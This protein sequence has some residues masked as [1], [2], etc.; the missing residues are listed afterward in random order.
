M[1]DWGEVGWPAVTFLKLASLLWRY[2]SLMSPDKHNCPN[3]LFPIIANKYL[4]QTRTK[5]RDLI[6]RIKHGG[7]AFPGSGVSPSDGG[8]LWALLVLAGWYIR[9]GA[10]EDTVEPVALVQTCVC[11]RIEEVKLSWANKIHTY[12]GALT[13]HGYIVP[14]TD[15]LWDGKGRERDGGWHFLMLV[16]YEVLGQL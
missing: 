9:P 5:K 11:A 7:R 12:L 13:R 14:I 3:D 1:L 16:W 10:A 6:N 15:E 2:G 4:E 8:S